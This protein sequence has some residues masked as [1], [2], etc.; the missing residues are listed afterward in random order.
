MAKISVQTEIDSQNL[1]LGASQMAL[2]ELEFMIRELNALVVRKK[3]ADKSTREKILLHKINHT[4]LTKH[5]VER[6]AILVKK[7]EPETMEASEL[8][9]FLSISE[10]EETLRN[11]RVK[12][13]IEL[14]QLQAIPLPQ[15]MNNLGLKATING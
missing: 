13:L 11:D 14:S 9:E 7:L 1:I 8:Q 5:E 15:L 10:K 3:N 4:V 12:Y 6:Y 2:S